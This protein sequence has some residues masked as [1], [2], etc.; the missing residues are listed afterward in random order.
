MRSRAGMRP[1][2]VRATRKANTT[3]VMIPERASR[4]AIIHTAK[5]ERNCTMTDAVPSKT[6]APVNAFT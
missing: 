2:A 3:I 1:G 5:V 4:S 6:R